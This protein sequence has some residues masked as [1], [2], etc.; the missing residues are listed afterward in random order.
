MGSG[1]LLSKF[2]LYSPLYVFGTLLTLIGSILLH[3][4]KVNTS[5]A[6]IVIFTAIA[7]L[8]VGVYSS[9]GVSVIQAKVTKKNLGQAIGFLSTG[10]MLGGA[11]SLSISATILINTATPR[12][13]VLFPGMSDG[14]IKNIIAGTAG[15][16][17]NDV[18]PELR[19]AAIDIIVDSIDMVFVIG[20]G[21]GAVGLICSGLLKYE[22]IMK[23]TFVGDTL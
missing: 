22:R 15:T 11:I 23:E 19:Q 9:T 10:L 5:S 14:I 16:S 17:L 8:G 1:F 4:S 13:K 20:V 3:F 12:L 2:G 21:A 7:G 18:G 6:K